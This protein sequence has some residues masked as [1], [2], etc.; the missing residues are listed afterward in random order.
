MDRDGGGFGLNNRKE[1]RNRPLRLPRTE[2]NET[3]LGQNEREAVRPEQSRP[4]G[5]ERLGLDHEPQESCL[6]PCL[7][8]DDAGCLVLVVAMMAALSGLRLL[9]ATSP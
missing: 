2:L 9:L 1:A 7:Q 4:E 3:P 8:Q 6:Q 5:T